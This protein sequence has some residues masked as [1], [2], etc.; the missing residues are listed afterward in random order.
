MRI[1]GRALWEFGARRFFFCLGVSVKAKWT[2]TCVFLKFILPSYMTKSVWSMMGDHVDTRGRERERARGPSVKCWGGQ[3]YS[4][5]STDS[6]WDGMFETGPGALLQPNSFLY[7]SVHTT[8]KSLLWVIWPHL[9]WVHHLITITFMLY[10]LPHEY[11]GRLKTG[12][13][14]L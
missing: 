12:K 10:C 13:D 4:G 5:V 1:S 8:P 14:G 3:V 9:A 6:S 7:F 11:K 2:W